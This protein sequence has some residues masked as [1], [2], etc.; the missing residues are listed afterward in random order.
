[1][2]DL[3]QL[4]E[5][6]RQVVYTGEPKVGVHVNWNAPKGKPQPAWEILL[7]ILSACYWTSVNGPIDLYTDEVGMEKVK[8]LG[9][10]GLY[11]KI[12]LLDQEMWAGFDPKMFWAAGKFMAML[13]CNEPVYIIDQDLVL[14]KSMEEY[15]SDV[16]YFHR[17]TL[18]P[19]WYPE[20]IRNAV[21]SMYGEYAQKFAYNCALVHFKSVEKMRKYA[22]NSLRF[23][24]KNSG[25]L[26]LYPA[27]AVMCS[28]EQFGLRQ[29]C[30]AEELESTPIIKSIYT[31]DRIMDYWEADENG[32]NDIDEAGNWI[33]HSWAEKGHLR[34]DFQASLDFSMHIITIL[35][36]KLGI[37]MDPLIKKLDFRENV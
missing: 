2:E 29:Y 8:N 1:M 19:D 5:P 3:T 6:L 20:N 25:G 12:H 15:N 10:G 24:N 32:V 26:S 35:E 30:L 36:R 13:E 9:L 16:V 18:S 33:Y 21:N 28:I 31:P 34:N 11:R 14:T 27:D 7:G 37:S 22:G 4:F 17:E 23:I